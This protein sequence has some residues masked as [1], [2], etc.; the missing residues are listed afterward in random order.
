MPLNTKGD[1]RRRASCKGLGSTCRTS[2]TLPCT[3][4]ARRRWWLVLLE[5]TC[6]QTAARWTH[7]TAGWPRKRRAVKHW[8]ANRRLLLP[9]RLA[10]PVAFDT[11]SLRRLHPTT[12]ETAVWVTAAVGAAHWVEAARAPFQASAVVLAAVEEHNCPDRETLRNAVA[13]A[14]C[15]FQNAPARQASRFRCNTA[16]PQ[17]RSCGCPAR[18]RRQS[19]GNDCR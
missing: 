13:V 19:C 8:V 3:C 14:S 4:I 2:C 6:P 7:C 1:R 17:R 18:N 9:L 11:R 5:R 12:T 16:A 10:A 15:R